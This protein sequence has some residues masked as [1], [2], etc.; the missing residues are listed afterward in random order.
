MAKELVINVIPESFRIA[1]LDNGTL[2][3]YHVE[4]KE[5]KFVVGDVYL[6]VVKKVAPSLNAAFVD[7][8][9]A[10]EAFLHYSDLGPQFK[11][12]DFFLRS[13]SKVKKHAC[14]LDDFV[15]QPSIDK[16]GKIGDVLSKDQRVLVQV[17]KEPISA[18]GPR[19]MSSISIAGR[20]IIVTPFVNRISI[21]KKIA[22]IEERKRLER[23][24]L[25]MK[26][27]NFGVIVRTVAEGK[28]A[29]ELDR[30]IKDSLKIWEDGVSNLSSAVPKDKIIGEKHRTFSILRDMLNESF[31][32][33]VVDD[34]A[35]YDDIKQY[36]LRIAPEKEKILNCHQGKT[37]LFEQYGIEKQIKLLFGKTVSLE[38]GGYLVIEHTEA[39]HVV[40]VNSGSATQNEESHAD[41]SLRINIAAAKEVCRQLRLR[42]MGGI[43]VVDFIDLQSAEHRELLH[44]EVKKHLKTDRSKT[45][46]LPL[47][48]FGIMQITR[49]RVRPEMNI[50]TRE[51]CPSCN[52]A[53]EIKASVS[54]SE[55][56]EKNVELLFSI[57]NEKALTIFLHPYLYSYFVSGLPSRRIKWFL[58]Y[59]KWVK[60]EEDSS[61]TITEFKIY[62]KDGMELELK[63]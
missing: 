41:A 15:I 5:S 12:T 8:G 17:T 60:L 48:K 11:S 37:K 23:L 26:P 24:M 58:K 16:L 3:E 22:S 35:V 53:G 10:K 25:S 1:L 51:Q 28:D 55:N 63:H 18:K 59:K 29:A 34:K 62:N 42:D 50:V 49:Q 45:K 30:D 13:A 32:N 54:I 21:S 2:L 61:L 43:I 38:S 4:D 27:K 6:G 36:I 40:D 47:S 7:I 19:L 44:E 20:Y 56:I 14:G 31:D 39:M 9:Y 33:I 52:G 46:S 57:Q